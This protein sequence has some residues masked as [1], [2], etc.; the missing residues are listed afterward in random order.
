MTWDQIAAMVMS[1]T[2]KSETVQKIWNACAAAMAR[3]GAEE[4]L[5]ENLQTV[6]VYEA[7][8]RYYTEKFGD[9]GWKTAR[10]VL[11]DEEYEKRTAK[12]PLSVPKTS[13]LIEEEAKALS[14]PSKKLKCGC[15]CRVEGTQAVTTG[16]CGREDHPA[17]R[18]IKLKAA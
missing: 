16:S 1:K 3:I 14:V 6:E 12:A 8:R 2:K 13:K 4:G 5:K 17:G 10:E 11:G 15:P 9:Y 18:T 7:G